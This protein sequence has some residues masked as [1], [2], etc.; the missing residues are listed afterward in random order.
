MTEK[1]LWAILALLVVL[2]V[3]QQ[4]R[5]KPEAPRFQKGISYAAW[6]HD[7][8]D[9]PEAAQAVALLKERGVEWVSLVVTWYQETQQSQVIYRDPRLTPD[10]EGL[11]QAIQLIHRLGMKV[12]LKPTVDVKD[13][14]WRGEVSFDHEEDWRAWFSSYGYFI[15][16]YADLA[17]EHG[18]EEFCVGVELL[19]TVHREPEWRWI[20]DGVRGRFE[21]PL[22]YAANWNN[23]WQ[24]DF[25]DA[26][27]YAGIDAY[28]ELAA[29]ESPGGEELLRAWA[30][31]VE[32][33]EV[34]HRKVGKP[35]L[36]TEVG[37]RSLSKAS[38]RPWDWA[39]AGEVDLH[40]Q[41]RYYEAT[42]RTF[43]DKPWFAGFYWWA[44]GP[45]LGRFGDDDTGYSPRGKPAEKV[46]IDWYA[47]EKE[48]ED[49]PF[50]DRS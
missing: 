45:K 21:G 18:V 43:W 3:I 30:P 28:F 19:G 1:L 22:T 32:E 44:W 35:I 33:L 4:P 7:G 40:E 16:Y 9:G 38:A 37:C 10:D 17:S 23:Y 41:A 48:V 36:F 25:W 49:G 26:L 14:T 29:G 12:L 5:M 20:I 13:G 39:A 11:I 2:L 6:K 24:V 31:W 46:L 27:D 42:F 15:N 8:Y 34:F 47:K 50:P